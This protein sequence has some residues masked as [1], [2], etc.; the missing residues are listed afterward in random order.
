MRQLILFLSKYRNTLLLIV[1]SGLSFFKHTQ[2]NP[3]AEH[4]INSVGF[5]TIASIQNSLNSW[6]G[7]WA[8]K[9]VNEELARENAAL[10]TS[11]YGSDGPA[12]Q[13]NEAYDY[14]P[15]QVIEY[16]SLIHI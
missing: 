16:L 13:T 12:F 10:R 14:I 8:L 4:R 11:I 5:R 7:Y 6:K 9:S 15:A 3:V 1:L 2:K